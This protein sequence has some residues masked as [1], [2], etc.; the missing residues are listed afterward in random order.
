MLSQKKVQLG[1][2]G[3]GE[4]VKKVEA[5][6]RMPELMITHKQKVSELKKDNLAMSQVIVFVTSATSGEKP[7]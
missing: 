6:K 1:L 7:S 4:E 3:R 5:I 2:G